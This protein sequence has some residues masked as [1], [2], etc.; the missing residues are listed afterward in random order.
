MILLM[1]FYPVCQKPMID[2]NDTGLMAPTRTIL[3]SSG[4]HTVEVRSGGASA[5]QHVNLRQGEVAHLFLEPV[6]PRTGR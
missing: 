4:A 2:G 1:T 5:S 6:L 3:L